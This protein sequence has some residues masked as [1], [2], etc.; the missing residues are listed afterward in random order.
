MENKE[1]EEY[2][3][4][5]NIHLNIEDNKLIIEIP[6]IQ[7]EVVT[8][9]KN[10]SLIIKCYNK[11]ILNVKDCLDKPLIK[12]LNEKEQMKFLEEVSAYEMDC[13]LEEDWLNLKIFI[14]NYNKKNI[15]N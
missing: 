3:K 13:I 1:L 9:K 11:R 12:I 14:E 7:N 6:N 15:T 10:Q 4:E 5:N 8:Y 2:L